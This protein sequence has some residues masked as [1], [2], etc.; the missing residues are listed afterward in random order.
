MQLLNL[1]PAA[2][3][4]FQLEVPNLSDPDEENALMLNTN[5][6]FQSAV[7]RQPEIIA[8]DLRVRSADRSVKLARGTYYPRMLLARSI[9]SGFS[10]APTVS[11]LPQNYWDQLNQNLGQQVYFALSIPLLNGLQVRTN[12]QCTR[13]N[14]QQVQLQAE[15]A[16]RITLR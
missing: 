3:P 4:N 6:L 15:Q 12:V 7:I 2:N 14:A 13:F 9:F 16:R 1:D 11:M 8:A 5:E 10:S